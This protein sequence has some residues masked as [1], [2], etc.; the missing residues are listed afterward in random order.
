MRKF[1]TYT[2]TV[3]FSIVTFPQVSRAAIIAPSLEEQ[4]QQVTQ[5]FTG[6]FN[7]TQQVTQEPSVTFISM[8]NCQVQLLGN[9]NDTEHVYLE[10]KSTAFE[11]IRLYSFS[12][13]NSA[14]KLS[15]R[16]FINPNIL[17]G[18]CN[19]PESARVVNINNLVSTSCDLLLTWEPNRYVANNAPSGC[20]TASGGKVVSDVIVTSSSINSLDQIFAAKGNLLVSTPIQFDRVSSIPEPSFISGLVAL[21]VWGSHKVAKNRY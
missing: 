15:I 13:D 3:L 1:K 9:N 7:N 18:I 17:S 20:V 12:Q 8:S 19:N 11:R 10:Q 6:S 21:G 5:W 2:L 4:V 14:V 16:S